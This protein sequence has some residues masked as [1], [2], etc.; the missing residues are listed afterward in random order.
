[1]GG[2]ALAHGKA[3]PFLPVLEILRGYFGIADGDDVRTAREKVAGRLLLLDEA[4]KEALPLIFEFL[5]V[6]DPDRPAPRI[7]PEAR[8]RQLFGALN[9]L[10]RARSD[11]APGVILVEDLHWLD[12]GSEAFLENLIEGVPGTRTLVLVNFRPEYGAGWTHKSYYRQIPLLPLGP[13]AIGELLSDLLGA[14]P[15]LD[16]LAELVTERTGGNPFYIEEVVQ[17]LA[18]TGSLEGTKG[19]YRLVHT[20]ENVEIPATVQSVLAARIDRLQEREKRLLQVAAVI[21][22]QFAEPV[23][24][25]VAGLGADELA[26]ALRTLVAAEFLYEEA[27]YPITEYA[28]KHALTEEV[29]Y[30]S[31]LGEARGRVHVAV[32]AALA[33]QDPEKLDERAALIAH[34]YEQGGRLLEAARWSARAA[35][36]AGFNDPAE[37]LRHWRR[38]RDLVDGLEETEETV[39]LA[40]TSRFMLIN[41][42]WRL[43]MPEEHDPG[44]FEREVAAVF[45]QAREIAER[46]A[47][48]D[49]L[50]ALVGTYGSLR[51][52]MG[53]VEEGLGLSREG[54]Q[55]AQEMG[56][57]GLRVAI[58][59]AI[60]YP[61][62]ILGRLPEARVAAQE[63]IELAGGDPSVGA[64]LAV[65]C[66]YAFLIAWRSYLDGMM[67]DLEAARRG[68]GEAIELAR[69]VGDTETEGW[70]RMELAHIEELA[71]EPEAAL[72]HGVQGVEM[73]ERAGGAFSRAISYLFLARA[74]IAREQWREAIA[75]AGDAIAIARERH[76]AVEVEA[77]NL[78]SVAE[79]RLGLGDVA[80]ALT[81]ANEARELAGARGTRWYEALAG[82][83]G[84]RALVARD[85]AAGA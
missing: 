34:H 22:R 16:G 42:S 4:F 24:A 30:R 21:G 15:S 29:A 57:A 13:E 76:V 45:E 31:Q 43:G 3:V 56:N 12:P 69:R 27:V 83:A 70:S 11:E 41:F 82:I 7:D 26:A 74:H 5:G 61:L 85:G 58:R 25:R 51:N 1:M 18:E 64:G 6:P 8:Q 52:L 80:G 73:A 49:L 55:L 77:W 81:T 71:G 44:E 10:L 62:C 14:D 67:G 2:A 66:P 84:A 54:D 48:K 33:E 17:E 65:A 46:T 19:E 78:I 50:P 39:G 38:V 28:F 20:I 23:L 72:A 63:G 32:A 60:V 9:R 75:A 36:W 35:G 40:L 68:L 59:P 47:A 53:H 79:A 37:A